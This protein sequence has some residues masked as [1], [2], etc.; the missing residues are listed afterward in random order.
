MLH[1]LKAEVYREIL[2]ALQAL[3][4][5]KVSALVAANAILDQMLR[6]TVDASVG[7]LNGSEDFGGDRNPHLEGE[8]D[9]EDVLALCGSILVVGAGAIPT[10]VI[11]HDFVDRIA[12]LALDFILEGVH[13]PNHGPFLRYLAS[14]DFPK[15]LALHLFVAVLSTVTTIYIS[16]ARSTD[17]AIRFYVCRK[18]DRLIRQQEFRPDSWVWKQP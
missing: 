13:S 16:I 8:F 9:R 15:F 14:L 18:D 6:A 7:G 4:N 12:R 5:L 17:R 1:L 11:R 2:L 10:V 3:E